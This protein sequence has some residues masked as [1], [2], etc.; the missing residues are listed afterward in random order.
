MAHATDPQNRVDAVGIPLKEIHLQRIGGVD[1]N[2]D[3]LENTLILQLLDIGHHFLFGCVQLQIV[4]AVGLQIIVLAADTGQD[5]HCGI[6]VLV[7]ALLHLVGVGGPG[8][9]AQC[10]GGRPGPHTAVDAD[11]LAALTLGIEIPKGFVD[12][13]AGLLRRLLQI[14]AEGGIHITGACAAVNHI[15]GAGRKQADLAA[16]C[17]RKGVVF[18]HQQCCR[19]CLGL[20]DHFIASSQ[21]LF[22]GCIIA[23]VVNSGRI[24]VFQLPELIAGDDREG[25][26]KH[27]GNHGNG[28]HKNGKDAEE[29]C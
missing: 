13:Q 1:Q 14:V 28:H 8:S 22:G 6:A 20:V 25:V 3:L 5:H 23:G 15:D 10:G 9:L 29:N 24:F 18:V 4:V 26:I 16:L 7:K 17:Q 19:F 12:H 11:I 21:P 27:S 2:N